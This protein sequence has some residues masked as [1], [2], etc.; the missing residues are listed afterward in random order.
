PGIPASLT[1]QFAERWTKPRVSEKRFRHI[2][3]VV[4]VAQRIAERTG[5]DSYLAM[6]AAWLHDACKEM[7]DKEL[8]RRAQEFGLKLHPIEKEYGHLLHGPVA[9]ATVKSELGLECDLVLDAIREH[10]L[11]AAPMSELSKV[12][13]LAD[14]LE[15]GRP[16]DYT[17]PI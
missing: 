3:G 16:H 4:N 7:K 2:C 15:Q 1:L 11:G 8:I 14:C 13:F 9:A 17:A 5:C 10:T 12:C 6:L